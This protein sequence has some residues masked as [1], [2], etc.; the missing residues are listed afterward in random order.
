[1]HFRPAELKPIGSRTEDFLATNK[2]YDVCSDILRRSFEN[3]WDDLIPKTR[4]TRAKRRKEPAVTAF[5][6]DRE[7]T[8]HTID[9]VRKLSEDGANDSGYSSFHSSLSEKD[10]G[11]SNLNH[12]LLNQR[13]GVSYAESV[14]QYE[15]EA[16]MM[17]EEYENHVPA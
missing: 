12:S 7:R 5:H 3:D 2:Q 17:E 4:K 1:M 11:Y 16:A 6:V 14:R 15:R 8:Q 10:P 9:E 13:T